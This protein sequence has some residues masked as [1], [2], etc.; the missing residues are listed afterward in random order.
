MWQALAD[1]SEHLSIGALMNTYPPYNL[2]SFLDSWGVRV[3]PEA[4]LLAR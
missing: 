2:A 4:I 1:G 3:N